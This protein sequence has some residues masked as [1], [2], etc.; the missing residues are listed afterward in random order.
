M[1]DNLTMIQTGGA[2]TSGTDALVQS[3]LQK[4]GASQ[5]QL[6]ADII[7]FRQKQQDIMG[8]IDA[9]PAPEAPTLAP[10]PTQAP[11]PQVTDVFKSMGSP[12]FMLGL[13][14]GALTGQPITGALKNATGY[15]TGI[16]KGDAAATQQHLDQFKEN[17]SAANTANRDALDAYH[18]ASDKYKNDIGKL[19]D[20]WRGIANQYGDPITMQAIEAGDISKAFSLIE[21][22]ERLH[23]QLQQHM[24]M[25]NLR[26]DGAWGSTLDFTM[27]DG[28]HIQGMRNRLSGAIQDINGKSVDPA[29]IS[30]E[31]KVPTQARSAPAL[32]LQKFIQDHP[33]A[34]EEEITNFAAGYAS[35][36]KAARDWATGPLGNQVRSFNVG[37]YH[38]DTLRELS[39]A[40]R[41]GDI[42]RFNSLA[43]TWGTET[44]N[45]APTNFE[46]AKQIIGAE[47]VKAIVGA[48]G[49][50]VQERLEAA[51][52]I[53]SSLSP[54]QIYGA[55]DTT[56][57]LMIG[58][59][60]GLK[61]QYERTTKNTDFEDQFLS[62][63]ARDLFT[64]KKGGGQSGGGKSWTYSAT[65]KGGVKIHSDDGV[66]WFN[67]DGSPFK[68]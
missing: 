67:P 54:D 66:N 42:K 59:L 40:L 4:L 15:L 12:M 9:T 27:K 19:M 29:D 58:Q 51:Q 36:V 6:S 18:A 25:L 43:N 13:L 14:G 35:R 46:T 39:D 3:L 2:D 50:G 7:P 1:P 24:D 31:D 5:K 17:V 30:R 33:D 65:G 63:E 32:A 23:E 21:A 41:N 28:R 37:L 45:P 53:S 10:V 61:Q 60:K 38:L 49:G 8:R 16:R 11:E 26:I 48:G 64:A 56:E 34:G 20:E 22:R 57:D 52:H 55:I 68:Q 47:V 62:P 44:G